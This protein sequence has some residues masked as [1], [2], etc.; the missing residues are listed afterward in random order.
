MEYQTILARP[1]YDFLRTNPRLK[2]ICYLTLSGS[3]AYGTNVEGSD[4]DIR[5]VALEDTDD[6]LLG[7]GLE[8]V[9][10]RTTDTV[11]YGLQK[12]VGICRDCNPNSV[13]LLGTRPEHI[14]YMNP[15]GQM[16]RESASLFLTKRAGQTFAGYATAQLRRIQNALAHDRYPQAE[17]ELHIKKSIDSMMM[18]LREQYHLADGDFTFGLGDVPDRPG[19]K[20]V[21]VSVRVEGMSLRRF[22][23]VNSDLR[24]MLR[25]YDK[26][27][28]RNRKKDDGHLYKHAMHLVR[29]YLTGIDVLEG[30]GI[31]TYRA[32]DLPLLMK[33]R[34]QEMALEEVFSLAEKLEERLRQTFATSAL[35]SA[36]DHAAID[37]LLLKA[38][39]RR[40]EVSYYGDKE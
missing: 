7:R 12:F 27:N 8:Q 18:I 31:R 34:R 32:D 9:E 6:L 39:A 1:E 28:H 2:H 14:L 40:N 24:T 25:N 21:T 19:E 36:P 26:L 10:D 4:L 29:L 35:P 38:Y 3:H 20:E 17:K 11:I 37:A 16:L 33:I 22:I 30:R 23:A 13:E 15:I 5:G